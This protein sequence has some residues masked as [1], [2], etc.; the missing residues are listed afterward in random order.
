MTKNNYGNDKLTI[1]A[2]LSTFRKEV[3]KKL[4]KMN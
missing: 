3:L 2:T 4:N 1:K